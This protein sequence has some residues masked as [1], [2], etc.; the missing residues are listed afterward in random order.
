MSAV[1]FRLALAALAVVVCAGCMKRAEGARLTR[2]VEQQ[3]E[4][5]AAFETRLTELAAQEQA[6]HEAADAALGELRATLDHLR[7]SVEASGQGSANLGAD[8]D[9]LRELAQRLDGR[10]A[11]I[12]QSIAATS[13]QVREQDAQLDQ[14][15]RLLAQRAG[16]DVTLR[17]ADI[18]TDRT[19]HYAAAYRAYQQADQVRARAL[20]G[21]YVRRY[22]QDDNADN[23]QYWI[24]KSYQDQ[25]QWQRAVASYRELARAYPRSDVLDQAL[26]AMSQCFYE[27]HDCANARTALDAIKQMRAQSPLIRDV[28]RRLRELRSPP[29]GY[30]T[31]G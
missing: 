8:L 11:E 25:Q 22:P 6:H 21:E 23:A 16:I 9:S 2:S 26:W 30:C 13:A 1:R 15:I 31:S 28:D 12:D 4:R 20:F 7:A 18:P 10:L 19:E 27:L 5:L 29:R 3:A 14:Q 17:D 24:G